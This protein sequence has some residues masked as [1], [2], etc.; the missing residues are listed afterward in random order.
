[1][2]YRLPKRSLTFYGS[3]VA[4]LLVAGCDSSTSP[5][6]MPP[7]VPPR[8]NLVGYQAIEPLTTP[9]SV[10]DDRRRLVISDAAT[11]AAFWNE[12]HGAV[13][14]KP[15]LPPVDFARQA[16]IA[17]TMGQRPTGGYVIEVAAVFEAEG[18]LYPVIRETSPEPSCVV[19]QVITAPAA[20]VIVDRA[21]PEITFVEE[22]RTT[23]CG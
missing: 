20:A 11:W 6:D 12:F 16:V 19:P 22:A 7:G 17:A 9:V 8:A 15:A 14:P 3:V 18:R 10:I 1:M 21:D 23:R 4:G 5:D 13:E 2:T